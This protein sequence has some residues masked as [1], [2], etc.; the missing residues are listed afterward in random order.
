MIKLQN[1]DIN[2]KDTITCG[3]CFRFIEE[4]N[5]SFTI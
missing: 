1:I 4:N 3:Q 2:L 5:G